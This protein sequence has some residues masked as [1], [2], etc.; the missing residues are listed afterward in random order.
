VPDCQNADSSAHPPPPPGR[1]VLMLLGNN[2]YPQDPR[3]AAEATSLTD[4]GYEV[5]VLCPRSPAQ[6]KRETLGGVQVVRFP[7]PPEG[8]S[9]AGYVLEAVHVTVTMLVYAVGLMFRRGFDVVHV[10]NPPDTL[11]LVAA[12]FKLFGKRF[13]YD[14]HDL[15]PELYQTNAGGRGNRLVYRT[16]VLLETLACRLAD[17][18]ITAN[19]SHREL[20]VARAGI[21][22]DKVTV[23][24]NGPDPARLRA[25]TADTELR[26]RAGLIIGWVGSMGRHDGVDHLIRAVHHLVH[27]LGRSDVLC[28]LVGHGDAY[29]DCRSLTRDLEMERYVEFAGFVPYERISAYLGAADV[30]AVPDPSS[31]YNDRSTMI[32]V[33]EYM[34]LSKPI[35]AYDLPETRISA[36]EAA[37]YAEPN[38]P[39]GLAEA[40]AALESDPGRRASMGEEGRRRVE[41]RLAWRHSV[42]NLL[43]AYASL[44]PQAPATRG[45]V[46]PPRDRTTVDVDA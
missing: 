26:A 9:F 11:V 15:A 20:E 19:T 8:T 44:T 23:V 13:L 42:P 35:V 45:R 2:P 24:R 16:L 43:E 37:V 12:V 18:V 30:C 17:H 10:H 38:D 33:M 29:D 27:G 7:H 36:G 14:H 40:I 28:V 39:R 1:R 22:F 25:E 41:D 5:T 46:Q 6:A 21:P 32:K 4:A 3:V 31:P 34:A